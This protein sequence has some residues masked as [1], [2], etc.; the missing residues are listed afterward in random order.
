MDNTFY[1]VL[2]GLA[3]QFGVFFGYLFASRGDY[4]IANGLGL[5]CAFT[6]YTT[7]YIVWKIKRRKRN[8]YGVYPIP[9]APKLTQGK[10]GQILATDSSAPS[11]WIWRDPTPEEKAYEERINRDPLG[12]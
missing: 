2:I 12:H 1:Y 5:L 4:L 10:D 9:P 8:C 7:F 11:G 3:I 6:F